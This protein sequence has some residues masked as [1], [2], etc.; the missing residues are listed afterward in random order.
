MTSL[1]KSLKVLNRVPD[2]KIENHSKNAIKHKN[3]GDFLLL[4]IPVLLSLFGALMVYSASKYSAEISY[5][6]KFYFLKKQLIGV[7][8]G[9][10]AMIFTANF[11]YMRL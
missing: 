10:V 8:L 3:Y 11:N 9:A 5:G 4:L 2:I 6:N 7:S 1:L